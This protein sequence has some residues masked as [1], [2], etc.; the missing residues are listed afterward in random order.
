MT[1]HPIQRI[2]A[3]FQRICQ[4]LPPRLKKAVGGVLTVVLLQTLLEVLA[5]LAIS[6]LALS[7]TAP[8]R[9][10]SHFIVKKIVEFVPLLQGL[11]EDERNFATGVAIA[12][13]ILMA[14]KMALE[15]LLT[16]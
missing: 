2:F 16:S 10:Q 5:I 13:A 9:L 11:M 12:T 4:V 15:L 1:F 8:E 3:D 6:G 7:V 14:A